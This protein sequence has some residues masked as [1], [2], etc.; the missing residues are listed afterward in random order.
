M[1]GVN[2]MSKP[3]PALC[4]EC[5]WSTE[6]KDYNWNLGCIN[7]KVVAKDKWALSR[8]FEGQYSPSEARDERGKSWPAPCGIKGR[9]W[10]AK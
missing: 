8:N 9:L 4:K 7:P 3:F 2:E 5:K 6:N 1:G 10:E